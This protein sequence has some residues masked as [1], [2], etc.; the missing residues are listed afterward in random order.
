[1]IL[2]TSFKA[3]LK[4]LALFFAVSMISIS[5]FPQNIKEGQRAHEIKIS[6]VFQGPPLTEITLEKLHGKVIVLEFWATWCAPCIAAF[7]HLNNLVESFKDKDVAFISISTDEGSDAEKKIK[8]LLS[9][10]P[11]STWVVKDNS[12]RSTQTSYDANALPK[13][14]V[15]DKFG[16][17]RWIGEPKKLSEEL[18]KEFLEENPKPIKA[19]NGISIN[20]AVTEFKERNP[21]NVSQPDT[22]VSILVVES[23]TSMGGFIFKKPNGIELKGLET[24]KVIE[25]LYD[26]PS[27]SIRKSQPFQ[28][29]NWNIIIKHQGI[30]ALDKNNYRQLILLSIG[31]ATKEMTDEIDVFVL[32]CPNGPKTGKTAELVKTIEP[33]S[34]HLSYQDGYLVASKSTLSD[35]LKMIERTQGFSIIDETGL[36]GKFEFLIRFTEKDIKSFTENLQDAGLILVK[37]KRKLKVLEVQSL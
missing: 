23:P 29:K 11:L 2:S 37:E 22:A 35:I 19:S 26:I 7:D 1:M 16:L 18:L 24:M 32:K 21:T 36:E 20:Q 3:S 25:W 28:S 5:S 13:T 17:I 12:S 6:T 8:S 34:L 10:V 31:V 15:I 9:K 4:E 30:K 27:S 33:G 14:I